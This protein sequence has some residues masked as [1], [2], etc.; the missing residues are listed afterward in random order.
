[1]GKVTY[2]FSRT[3][4]EI[5]CRKTQVKLRRQV[6]QPEQS[7][8]DAHK[9]RSYVNLRGTERNVKTHQVIYVSTYVEL[10]GTKNTKSQI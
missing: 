3:V 2:T 7:S 4:F 10:S 8:D 6:S 9:L 1:M 5:Q